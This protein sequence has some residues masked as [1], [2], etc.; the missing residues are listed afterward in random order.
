MSMSLA[1]LTIPLNDADTGPGDAC[2]YGNTCVHCGDAELSAQS[3]HLATLLTIEGVVDTANV[4]QLVERSTRF[5]MP[6]TAF[7]FDVSGVTVCSADAVRLVR[8]IDDACRELD[9][10][11]ALVASPAVVE[12]LALNDTAYPFT[13]SVADALHF[14]AD[15]LRDRRRMLLPLLTKQR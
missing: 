10:D 8:A 9:V 12:R 6:G 1:S 14:F 5:V 15:Q 11:W 7:V 3:R 4:G 13:T 2:C